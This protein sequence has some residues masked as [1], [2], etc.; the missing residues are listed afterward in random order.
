MDHF[1]E[2]QEFLIDPNTYSS[3]FITRNA[4]LS[5]NSFKPQQEGEY[6][7]LS[8]LKNMSSNIKPYPVNNEADPA[9]IDVPKNTTGTNGSYG[10][11]AFLETSA[12]LPV[13]RIPPK[14]E[15]LPSRESRDNDDENNLSSP[16]HDFHDRNDNLHIN[17][18]SSGAQ[19]TTR[20]T[21]DV[22]SAKSYAMPAFG[23]VRES[24]EDY[25]PN[26]HLSQR[27]EWSHSKRGDE[28]SSSR[29]YT[30][31]RVNRATDREENEE[32]QREL[33]QIMLEY[34][35]KIQEKLYEKE[36]S[37][38]A[39]S[40]SSENLKAILKKQASQIMKIKDIYEGAFSPISPLKNPES[41]RI[42]ESS[43]SKASVKP[44]VLQEP[45]PQPKHPKRE[46]NKSMSHSKLHQPQSQNKEILQS[47]S[48]LPMNELRMSGNKNLLDKIL[49]ASPSTT[50]SR[51]PSSS[52]SKKTAT[53]VNYANPNVSYT[54]DKDEVQAP[55][56]SRKL[57]Q[58]VQKQRP[59]TTSRLER[60]S[61]LGNKSVS[62][63]PK[64]PDHSMMAMMM[65]NS[66]AT[67]D[68][69]SHQAFLNFWTTKLKQQSKP[70]TP[71]RKNSPSPTLSPNNTS[72]TG[73]N[74]HFTPE[75]KKIINKI[76]GSETK[77]NEVKSNSKVNLSDRKTSR[78]IDFSN[79]TDQNSGLFNPRNENIVENIKPEIKKQK[80]LNNSISKYHVPEKTI[81][82]V[83]D[84]MKTT[85]HQNQ[86]SHLTSFSQKSSLLNSSIQTTR[87]KSVGSIKTP[88]TPIKNDQKPPAHKVKGFHNPKD[89]SK[90]NSTV[91]YK[92]D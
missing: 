87:K 35:Q 15:N 70:S 28:S 72:F 44:I 50:H 74:P 46:M 45:Q 1:D 11:G 92:W 63:V 2:D 41:S 5:T 25:F 73:K 83:D 10:S 42:V 79:W 69:K 33:E 90:N 61:S 29:G 62:L 76:A 31:G 86:E 38:K 19:S 23:D 84:G 20:Q 24:D 77:R 7:K 21:N 68:A 53:P 49:N 30:S 6:I 66:M 64:Y 75:K 51:K 58:S 71:P 60:D 40:I 55:S 34:T 16:A 52:S 27:I 3:R 48:S 47:R 65:E 14:S 36:K 54:F 80:S 17:L 4:S 82:K 91:A 8:S 12:E 88:T 56:T 78:T 89:K 39:R 81:R 59:P 37:N 13:V 57:H 22:D 18:R 43:F 67:D 85:R 32:C 26:P 9:Y